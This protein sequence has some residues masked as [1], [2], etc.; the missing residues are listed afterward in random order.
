LVFIEF[1]FLK[2][3]GLRRINLTEISVY[4]P[5]KFCKGFTNIV[6]N[7]VLFKQTLHKSYVWNQFRV[8]VTGIFEEIPWDNYERI[9]TLFVGETRN[10]WKW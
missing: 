8:K 6:P 7:G 2:S 3:I 4:H 9:L 1:S 5:G 10:C